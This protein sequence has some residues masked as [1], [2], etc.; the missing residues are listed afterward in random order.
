[1]NTETIIKEKPS[2]VKP[3]EAHLG[4]TGKPEYTFCG[5]KVIKHFDDII[6]TIEEARN[7]T[8]CATCLLKAQSRF[9]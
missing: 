5:K 6:T 7:K 1:M 4:L 2:D 9:R 3:P 8:T